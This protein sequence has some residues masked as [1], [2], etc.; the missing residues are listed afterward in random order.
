PC[1]HW[2]CISGN[3]LYVLQ[4]REELN[5]IPSPGFPFVP[6]LVVITI[7]PLAACIPYKAVAA[8][9]FS[10]LIDSIS[11]GLISNPRLVGC[12][13]PVRFPAGPLAPAPAL[14]GS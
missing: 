1:V 12:V 13:P 4:V 6:F 11:L 10:T 14:V 7:A 2:F 9:P 5:S 3:L 8:G